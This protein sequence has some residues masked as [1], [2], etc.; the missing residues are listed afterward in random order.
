MNLWLAAFISLLWALAGGGLGWWFSRLRRPYWLLGYLIPLVL[1]LL[2]GVA[3][4]VPAVMF[5]PPVSWMMLGLKKFAVFG[6]VATM[7]L[8]TPLSRLTRRRDRNL[9]LLL[10]AAMVFFI[11]I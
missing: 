2:F 6:F 1:I 7:V 5:T 9:I 3:F 10:M 8:T 11:A 4:N